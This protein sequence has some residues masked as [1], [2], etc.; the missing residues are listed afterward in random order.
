M[1]HDPGGGRGKRL[2]FIVVDHSKERGK[3]EANGT[4]WISK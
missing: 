4:G 1:T 2:R 3:V